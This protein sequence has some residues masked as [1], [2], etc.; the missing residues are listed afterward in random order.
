MEKK[1]NYCLEYA[2]PVLVAEVTFGLNHS[3][4]AFPGI[5]DISKDADPL[6]F[7][8]LGWGQGWAWNTQRHSEL[9]PT[10]PYMLSLLN[11]D[12]SL[13]SRGLW[14]T[15]FL[16]CL[17]K[18]ASPHCLMLTAPTWARDER[19]L[20]SSEPDRGQNQSQ[21][22]LVWSGNSTCHVHSGF[23]E[24]HPISLVTLWCTLSARRPQVYVF[25]KLADSVPSV[26]DAHLL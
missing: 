18:K 22:V 26:Q 6:K 15:F 24:L 14:M 3:L 21:K 5:C 19:C 17:T 7:L 2:D 13:R 8:Q 10:L 16:K 11:C 25:L 23:V 1:L 12:R 4:K 9:A 20:V